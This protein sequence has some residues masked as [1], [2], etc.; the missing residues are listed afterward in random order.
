MASSK[1][2]MR[3][4]LS[5]TERQRGHDRGYA[6]KRNAVATDRDGVEPIS[7]EIALDTIFFAAA[8]IAFVAV[9]AGLADG[10]NRC[11]EAVEDR[12]GLAATAFAN[13][14]TCASK[15]CAFSQIF[16]RR[17]FLRRSFEL[18]GNSLRKLRGRVRPLRERGI[19]RGRVEGQPRPSPWR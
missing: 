17:G 12:L 8:P 6:R 9:T 3:M 19:H 16:G 7:G 13:A 18:S 5:A 10:G 11:L 14:A 15:S 4:L 1:R 2:R